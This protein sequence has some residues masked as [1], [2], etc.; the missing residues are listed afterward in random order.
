M[1]SLVLK[2][3][4]QLLGTQGRPCFQKIKRWPNA[5]P[6]P[7]AKMGDRQSAARD[8]QEGNNGLY[9]TGSH[10]CGVS[11]PNCLETDIA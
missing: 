3:H 7:D 11:L 10:L 1:H 8:L 5:I 9:F 4:Q 6:L 2:E